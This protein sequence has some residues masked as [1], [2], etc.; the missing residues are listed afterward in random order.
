MRVISLSVADAS[1][2]L[3]ELT[4]DLQRAQNR[5]DRLQGFLED[6]LAK[7]KALPTRGRS[8]RQQK[9]AEELTEVVDQIKNGVATGEG[10]FTNHIDSTFDFAGKPGLDMVV[11]SIPRFKKDIR[12]LKVHL[13]RWPDE[14]TVHAYR[15]LG[16]TGLTFFDQRELEVGEVV[17]LTRAQAAGWSDRFEAID[18]DD[19]GATAAQK[20]S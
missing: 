3:A 15:F 18:A 4:Q 20:A 8:Y 1:E 14:T 7:L 16:G 10:V 12:L 5:R 13:K 19:N 9:T 6:V 2:R 17:N 11:E